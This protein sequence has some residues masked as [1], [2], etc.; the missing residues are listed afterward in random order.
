MMVPERWTLLVFFFLFFLWEGLAVDS[1]PVDPKPVDATPVDDSN[2]AGVESEAVENDEMNPLEVL[3]LQLA[4]LDARGRSGADWFFWIAALSLIN[5]VILLSGGDTHFVVGLGVTLVADV[6]AKSV[7]EQQP[8]IAGTAQVVAFVFD[9][10]VAGVMCS[11]GWLSRRGVLPVFALG[12]FLYLLDGLIY[13][14][15][16]DWLS[17]GF[18][19]FVLFGM[20][21]GFMAYRQMKTIKAG[22][23][24]QLAAGFVPEP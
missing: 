6:I 14:L 2:E 13:V 9:L 20:W 4:Q 15:I 19:A 12:M 3:Q 16:G 11:F 21:S 1:K 8:E 17:V 23:E 24:Q 10:L 7:A 18:H 5:S 22:L